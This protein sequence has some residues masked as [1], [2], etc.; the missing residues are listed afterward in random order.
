M[1]TLMRQIDE[2]DNLFNHMWQ[3]GFGKAGASNGEI[4]VLRPRVDVLEG[5]KEFVIEADLPGVEKDDLQVEV[6][7]NVLMIRAERK[8]ARDESV[9]PLRLERAARGR[10]ERHF[11]LGK[12]IDADR[13][14]GKLHNGVLH[15]VVP[16]KEKALP[17]RIEVR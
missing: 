13:I 11:T 7:R 1:N 12:E 2:I 6:E 5:E 8:V 10:F 15:L 3:S 14:E 4:A 17:R 9:Q 16:K